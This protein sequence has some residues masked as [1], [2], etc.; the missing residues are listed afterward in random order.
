M[1][2]HFPK[3]KVSSFIAVGPKAT[4]MYSTGD[5]RWRMIAAKAFL[6]VASDFQETLGC[7]EGYWDCLDILLVGGERSWWPRLGL[8]F[9]TLILTSDE[10]FEC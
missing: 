9:E 7:D 6:A 4:S 2:I 10:M 5:T 3:L 1:S 8:E